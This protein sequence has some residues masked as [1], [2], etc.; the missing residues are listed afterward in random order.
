MNAKKKRKI[1]V[2]NFLETGG[3]TSGQFELDD[4]LFEVIEKK[5]GWDFSAAHY[6]IHELDGE[7]DGFVLSGVRDKSSFGNR[8]VL[9]HPTRDLVRFAERTPVYTGLELSTLFAN[10]TVRKILRDDQYFFKGKKVLFNTAL[11]T[12]FANTFTEIGAEVQSADPLF[13]FGLPILLKSNSQIMRFFR[14]VA[15]LLS[16]R[17]IAGRHVFTSWMQE[18]TRTRLMQWVRSADVLVTYSALL[19][20]VDEP[21]VFERKVVFTDFLTDAQ[22]NRIMRFNPAQIIEYAPNLEAVK[23]PTHLWSFGMLTAVMDQIRLNQ[24]VTASL[25]EFAFEMIEG[26]RLE[27]RRKGNLSSV[28]RRCAFVI[29]PLSVKHLALTPGMSW[30]FHSPKVV[31]RS[32]EQMLAHVPVFKY[33]Q[34]THARSDSTGQEVICD[35]YALC[36]TP[37]A[38]LK[39]DENFIYNQLVAAAEHA[40][41]NGAVMIGLGAYTKVIGDS[42]VTVARRSPIPVT[43]GNSY[44]ASATLWAAREMVMR[45][46][47]VRSSDSRQLIPMKVMVV[48]ATGS[49]GRVSA[50][51]LATVAKT[52]V[53]VAP[54]P[55]KLL[56]L[57]DELMELS[58]EAEI[59]VRTDPDED[60]SDTDLIVTATSNQRGQILDIMKV[61]PGAVICDCSRPLDIR[62]EEA[63]RRPDVLV[64]ESGEIDLPGP[65]RMNVDIGLEK[66]SVYA[67][68][69]ETV[70]L[71]ME[72]RYESFSLSRQL[73]LAKVKE[74]YQ[75]GLKHGA[76]L[77]SIRTHEG[78]LTE[79]MLN[80][81][82]QLARE[83]RRDWVTATPKAGRKLRL[84]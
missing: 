81:C 27:P 25:S 66:P 68:L 83:R 49:I 10:W 40:H 57:R 42:G 46:G 41:K 56:E 38:M 29:H 11:Y 17:R 43:T 30:L 31:V 3:D 76:K 52:V 55:D 13:L 53:I 26:M 75:L 72:G 28:P 74:I 1:I 14:I 63:R 69:A 77:S 19:G 9:H 51:L 36:A 20:D 47:F 5:I 12:P 2:F 21:E 82:R 4:I 79:E 58:P 24:G 50:Q 18:N 45:M 23:V 22:R 78:F 34:L 48:G 80:R 71:T 65:V 32:A 16:S 84:V 8:E 70:L 62:P 54:R 35:I 7:V 61:Q 39:M 59:L 15:P 33:G 6:H 37:R 73:Q 67:C 60:L 44:S 64:I